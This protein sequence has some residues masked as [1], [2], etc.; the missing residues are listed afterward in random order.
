M[1]FHFLL[2]HIVADHAFT[3]NAKIR[4]YSGSKLVGHI[5]W[6][7]LAILAFTF[8]VV[9]SST[10]GMILFLVL[11][12]VHAVL[13][14]LRVK[15][16]PVSRRIVDVIE[17]AGIGFA[18]LINGISL[19]LLANSYLSAEFV[20]Y[21]L[22]MSTVSVGVT[23]FFR[24]FYPGNENLADVDG[25]SERLAI[26]IFLLA[27]KPFYVFISIVV[28]LIYRLLFVKKVDHTWWISPMSGIIISIIW[29]M[30][31]YR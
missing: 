9:F 18:F 1:A 15:Y 20:F 26:Y 28:A 13:D 14:I 12:F 5:L 6:S 29:R 3:N 31:L 30:A 4:K 10:K 22:G 24:N 8:D 23:Y 25:I 7:I 11:A 27:S 21:L 19:K 17:A 2:G 16:Y